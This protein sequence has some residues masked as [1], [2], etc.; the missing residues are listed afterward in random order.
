MKTTSRCLDNKF[1]FLY[2]A[3]NDTQA[4][5]RFTDTKSGAVI[6]I[7]MGLIAGT[8]TLFEKYYSAL[9]SLAFL[10]QLIATLGMAVC[11][12]CLFIALNLALQSINPVNNP[13]CHIDIG[14]LRGS[15][16]PLDYYVS[17]LTPSMRWEDYYWELEDS[18]LKKS[19]SEFY[20]DLESCSETEL[21]KALSFEFL[22]LSYIKEKKVHRAKL[23][24]KW[25]ERCIWI[26]AISIIMVIMTLNSTIVSPWTINKPILLLFCSLVLGHIIGEFFY[27]QRG[28]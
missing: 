23:S 13:N 10:P 12:I 19:M 14:D 17:G 27:K 25:I 18:Q 15:P 16:T 24:I 5:I 9:M 2:N 1:D 21:L 8:V 3:I 4:T 28:K 6:V 7:V 11:G 20:K 22:K 26:F